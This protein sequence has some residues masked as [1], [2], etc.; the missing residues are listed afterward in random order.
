MSDIVY[1]FHHIHH[2]N[3]EHKVHHCGGE[4]AK[5]DPMVDYNIEHCSCKK[6]RIDKQEVFGHTISE[7]NLKS[8]PIKIKFKETCPQGGWHIES[9]EAI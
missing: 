5:N 8:K 4:H 7:D 2:N 9:G 6:H 3:G 1:L